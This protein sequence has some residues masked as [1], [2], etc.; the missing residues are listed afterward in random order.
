M[1]EIILLN[2]N[3]R[4][5]INNFLETASQALHHFRYFNSRPLDVLDNHLATYLL[6]LDGQMVGYGHLD[7]EGDIVWLGIAISDAHQ[8]IGLGQLMMHLL[9]AV[10]KLN[11]LSSIQLAVD[12]DNVKAISLYQKFGFQTFSKTSTLTFMKLWL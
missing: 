7:R 11:K 1:L 10:A 6:Q 9:I 12:N 3:N 5:L 8:G 2:K 4:S